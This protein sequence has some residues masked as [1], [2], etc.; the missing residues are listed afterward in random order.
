MK[1]IVRR[2]PSG[3]EKGSMGPLFEQLLGVQIPIGDGDFYLPEIRGFGTLNSG[4]L[5]I[6]TKVIGQALRAAGKTDVAD[7]LEKNIPSTLITLRRGEY[8]IA[9]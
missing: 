5:V 3:L 9:Q 8:E 6:P 1:I 7:R 4:V 2:I